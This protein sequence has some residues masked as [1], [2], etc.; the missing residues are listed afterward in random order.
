MN[1]LHPKGC[2]DRVTHALHKYNIA[3]TKEVYSHSGNGKDHRQ[4]R[5]ILLLKILWV[6]KR[7]TASGRQKL[8]QVA[9]IYNIEVS[10]LCAEKVRFSLV[11][12]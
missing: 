7:E 9:K 10:L 11:H 8:R 3:L 5:A 2:E 12:Y 1:T 4:Q 6:K